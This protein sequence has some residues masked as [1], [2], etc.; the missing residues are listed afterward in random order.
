M[1]IQKIS[2]NA[3]RWSRLCFI[4]LLQT[5]ATN[6]FPNTAL[7]FTLLFVL[8]FSACTPR[9]D[10]PPFVAQATP[11]VRSSVEITTFTP[12][13]VRQ[14]TTHVGWI[15]ALV[16]PFP[17]VADGLTSDELRLAWMQGV[18]PAVFSGHSLLMEDSTLA[19]LTA[20]WG[21]PHP[22]P[23]EACQPI[24][25]SRPRGR[26]VRGRSSHSNRSNRNGRC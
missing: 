23:C 22:A 16:A 8:Q 5:R 14:L 26:S 1:S 24:N 10:S 13:P 17:T 6:Q 21:E 3:R 4:S 20:L 15:Y 25:C 2:V 18:T 9:A 7:A 19:A 12:A 11:S